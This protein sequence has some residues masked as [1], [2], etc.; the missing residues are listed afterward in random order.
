MTRT[1]TALAALLL[2]CRYASAAPEVQVNTIDGRAISGALKAIVKDGVTIESEGV[3]SVVKSAELHSL[4][5]KSTTEPQA[6]KPSAWI[7]LVDGSRLPAASFLSK[8]GKVTITLVNGAELALTAKDVSSVRYSKLDQPDVDISDHEAAADLLGIRKRETVDFLEGVIGDITADAVHFTVDGQTIPVNPA[9]VDRLLY[10]RRASDADGPAPACVVEESNGTVLKARAVELKDDKLQVSLL[11]GGTL[12]CP[13]EGIHR[14]DYSSGKLTYLSD[15]KPQSVQWTPFFDLGK[16]SPALARFLGPRF[17]RGR[18]DDVM[19]LDG[20]A[21]KKGISLTS[22][23]E[24][25]YKV[26]ARSR[27]FQ[28]LAG[29]DDGVGDLG[30]VQ[31]EIKGDG[32]QLYSGKLTGKD[33]PVALDLDLTGVRRLMILVDF[34][35]DLDVADHLNL[36]EARIVK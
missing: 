5:F 24:M 7:E 12:I 21:Y 26:P 36:C 8:D 22:R 32:R 4:S 19:R 18:E 28:A 23:T 9:K 3:E 15:L 6:E 14:L 29:I 30:N 33:P 11:G 16:Q 31:L 13:L 27:R 34:G 10:A 17:D 20:K 25:V 1:L 2:L 35:D